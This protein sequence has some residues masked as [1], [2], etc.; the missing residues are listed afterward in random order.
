[1][2]WKKALAAGAAALAVLILAGGL[3][4]FLSGPAEEE[5][6][7]SRETREITRTEP[8]DS[9]QEGETDKDRSEPREE[10]QDEDNPAEK[11]QDE[12]YL[13]EDFIHKLARLIYDNYLPVSPVDG[14][15]RL[16]LSFKMVNMRFATDLSDFEVDQENIQEARQKVLQDLLQ[17]EVIRK[18]A[19]FYGA[20]L[21]ARIQ[22]LADNQK[23]TISKDGRQTERFLTRRETA[24]LFE[25]LSAASAYTAKVFAKC[26]TDPGIM[27]LITEYMQ[28]AENLQETYFEYWQVE[29]ESDSRRK[30]E[31]GQRIKE[32]I[33]AREEVREKI[34]N[35]VAS[36]EMIQSGQDYV[37]QVQWIY[38]RLEEDG[39]SR[40]AIVG[41]A[42]AGRL[43]SVMAGDRA[44][45]ILNDAGQDQ[46]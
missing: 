14:T 43:F 37:Y 1:M 34:I 26:V 18:L 36:Q 31:L 7:I 24:E 33:Q 29:D 19:A 12:E 27:D 21:L 45:M 17:P 23:K 20:R 9:A 32:L 10:E 15:S 46:N 44:E 6:D 39:F 28:V 11:E 13:S 42:E 22:Y 2:H 41:L 16:N 35:R 8:R 38:R 40:A 4:F 30:Q 3:Y 5:T 25:K